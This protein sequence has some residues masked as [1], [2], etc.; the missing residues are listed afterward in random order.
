MQPSQVAP[1]EALL[2]NIKQRGQ[3]KL[4]A[5]YVGVK[6]NRRSPSRVRKRNEFAQT[7][8]RAGSEGAQATMLARAHFAVRD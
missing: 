1:G 6:A 2:V 4:H 5:R 3:F 7:R 8:F